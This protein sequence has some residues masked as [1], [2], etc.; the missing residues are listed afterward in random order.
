MRESSHV[1]DSV[2]PSSQS[3]AAKGE[4]IQVGGESHG[5]RDSDGDTDDTSSSSEDEEG[6]LDISYLQGD[7]LPL[8]VGEL[9]DVESEE[10]GNLNTG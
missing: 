4:N 5:K 1:S 8:V 9:S 3:D 6:F 2:F 10:E 7:I